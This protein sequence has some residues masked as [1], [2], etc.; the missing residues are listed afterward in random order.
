MATSNQK[1][2][3]QNFLAKRRLAVSLLNGSSIAMDDIVYEIGPGKGILTAELCKR[4]K[5]VIAIEKDHVLYLKLKKKF[6]FNDNIILYNAD[7]LR[8]RIKESCYKVFANMPF[9]ITSA[10]IRKILC[11]ANSPADA[12]L[13]VQREAAEKFTGTP[14][15]TQ[16]SVLLKPHFR[17]KIIRRFKRTD[18]SPV[19]NVDVVML[20]IEK[21]TSSLVSAADISAYEQF[22]KRGFGAWRKDLKSNYKHVFSHNQWK[23]LSRDLEFPIR[24]KPSEIQFRQWLGLFDFYKCSQTSLRRTNIRG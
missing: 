17:P 4:A 23:R 19:P 9:N 5:K 3:A 21:R 12:Y 15:T 13:I 8:F 6:E 20:H 16:F 14:R 1:S 11:A 10:A 2:L 7:F 18:F 24:A 22:I